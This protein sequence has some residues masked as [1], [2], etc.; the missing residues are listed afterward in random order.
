MKAFDVFLAYNYD[1]FGKVTAKHYYVC[2]YSQ[3]HDEN[4]VLNN[5]VY[6][7]QITTNTKYLTIHDEYVVE[8]KNYGKQA[9]VKCDMITRFERRACILREDIKISNEKKREI[10]L[11][12]RRFISEMNHQMNGATV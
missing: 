10:E 8:I 9:F 6:G 3:L 4:T 11:K 7:L 2:V 1:A 12:L 5:D